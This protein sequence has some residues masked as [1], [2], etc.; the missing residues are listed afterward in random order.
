MQPLKLFSWNAPAT[1]SPR[2]QV[3]SS[4]RAR[5][6]A[7]NE[8]GSHLMIPVRFKP[9]KSGRWCNG[10]DESERS[11]ANPME[12][13]RDLNNCCCAQHHGGVGGR[14]MPVQVV[15]LKVEVCDGGPEGSNAR[16]SVQSARRAQAGAEVGAAHSSEE[17]GNDAGAKGACLNEA[18]RERKDKMMACAGGIVTPQQS[19]GT[20]TEAMPQ[21]EVELARKRQVREN[22]T[23]ERSRKAGCGRPARPV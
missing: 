22:Q 20:L 11:L 3:E 13:G 12:N 5:Q 2:G 6:T 18:N 4:W 23:E 16:T 9:V 8:N 14:G 15:R 19:S 17:G 10:E 1:A 7:R 21:D